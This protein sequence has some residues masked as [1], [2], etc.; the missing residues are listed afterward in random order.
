MSIN[1]LSGRIIGCAI[2]IH[3]RL[4]PGLLENVY[5]RCMEYELTKAGIPF[6]TEKTLPVRYDTLTIEAGYRADLIIAHQII[7]EIKSVE[8]VSDIH[9]AQLLTYLKMSSMELGLLLNFKEPV[10]K[11]GITRMINSRTH[12]AEDAEISLR[13]QR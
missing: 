6:E 1:D 3:R 11:N 2:E 10:L 4:G 5:H 13:V 7:V 9:R 8:V 12:H